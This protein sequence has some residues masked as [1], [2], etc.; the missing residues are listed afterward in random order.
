MHVLRNVKITTWTIAKDVLRHVAAVLKNVEGWLDNRAPPIFWFYWNYYYLLVGVTTSSSSCSP[1]DLFGFLI[2]TNAT[3]AAIAATAAAAMNVTWKPLFS[4]S[5][6][7]M[8]LLLFSWPRMQ[9]K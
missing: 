5:I 1:P 8:L 6:E 3:T 4:A 9:M 7:V 2:I